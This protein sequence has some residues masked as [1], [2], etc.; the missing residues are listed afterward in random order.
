MSDT[1]YDLP[2]SGREYGGTY[3]ARCNGQTASCTSSMEWAMK[4]VAAKVINASGKL[5]RT[6]TH[7]EVRIVKRTGDREGLFRAHVAVAEPEAIAL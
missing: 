1:F 4:R 7:E 6:V 3:I 2:V 5:K